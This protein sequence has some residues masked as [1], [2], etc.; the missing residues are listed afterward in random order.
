MTV[1]NGLPAHVLLVHLVVVLIPLTAVLLLLVAFWPAARRHL[2][3]LTAALALIGLVSVPVTTNAGHWLQRRVPATPLLGVHVQLG[4][5]MLPWAVGLAVV[6]LAFAA[7]Q[8]LAHRRRP[9]LDAGVAVGAGREGP[10]AAVAAR[11]RSAPGGR[12]LSVVLAVLAVVV[13]VGSVFTVYRIG[14]S[15]AQAAWTGH[16][17]SVPLPRAPGRPS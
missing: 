15:G 10:G 2:S 8:V 6:A 12:A 5:T 1:I 16:F 17:V 4:D 9:D 7:R 3:V 14:D 13:A 11:S